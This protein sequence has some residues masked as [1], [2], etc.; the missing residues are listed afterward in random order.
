MA[1][2]L[3]GKP[4]CITGASSG[5]GLATA[6]AC[7]KAGMPVVL[8]ARRIE[9]LNTL[10]SQITATGGKA[11]AIE[12]DVRDTDA[13]ARMI[14][15]CAGSFGSVYSV[16]ANAG[17]GLEKPVLAM[18]DAELRDIFETNFFGT[19]NTIRPAI[20]RMIEA[21][22]GHIVVCSSCLSR[23]SIPY[24]SAYS[25]TKS[26]QHHL[27]RAMNLELEGQG[28]RVSSVH[29]IGTK[30]E[31]FDAAA[32]NSGG[33]GHELVQHT[34]QWFLQT[35][36]RVARAI[37][38]RLRRPAPEIWTSQATRLGMTFAEAMPR[39]TDLFLRRMVRERAEKDARRMP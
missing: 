14:D 33:D 37:V 26:A 22:S 10:A 5:I 19:L 39:L 9:R 15:L 30:T 27:S 3:R 12:V 1:I 8:A 24:F 17:Y 16:F 28:I 25:A 36:E 34:A 2:D 35:P 6:L 31:F 23:M 32:R 38:R 20:P 29:P 21:R 18:S 4:I 7:A 13:C 11:V